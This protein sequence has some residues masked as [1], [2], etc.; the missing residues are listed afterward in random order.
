MA[1][2]HSP[3]QNIEAHIQG[4]ISGQVAVGNYNVQ[5]GSIHGGVVNLVSPEQ[6][7]CPRPRPSPVFLRPRPFPKLLDRESEV[8]A[9]TAALQSATPVEFYGQDGLGKTT[10]QRYL[11]YQPSLASFPDGVVY[12]SVRHQPLADLLQS[13][14]DAFY[15]SDVPFKPTDTQ[16]RHDLQGKRALI[17]LDDVGLTRDEV[18]TLMDAAP[19]CAFL[20]ASRQRH[21]WGEGRTMALRGLPPDNAMALLER[22]LGRPLTPE[23]RPAAQALCTALDGNPLRILQAAAMVREEGRSLTEVSRRIQAPSPADTLTAEILK[24]LPESKRQ[25]LAALAAL[26]GAPLHVDHLAALTGIANITPTLEALQSRNLVQAHSP[27]YSL[28]GTLGDDLRHQWD[29]NQWA[30]RA[31]AHFTAWAEENRSPPDRLL[32]ETDV[33]LQVLGWG[34]NAGRWAEVLRLARAAEGALALGRRWGA[35]GQTLQWA[36]QAARAQQ[37]RAAEAWVLHQLGTR[38]LCLSR[39]EE[40]R[41][42][43]SQ[44]L[45]IREAIDD[46]AGAAVTR[47]NLNLLPGVPPP[48]PRKPPGPKAGFSPA[49]RL[50]LLAGALLS[51]GLLAAI[52]IRVIALPTLLPTATPTPPRASTAMPAP[53]GIPTPTGKPT[54]T[55]RPTLTA[56]AMPA[57]TPAFTTSLPD[58]II[59]NVWNK[60]RRVIC[61]QIRNIGARTAPKGHSVLLLV[62]GKKQVKDFIRVEMPPEGQFDRCFDY[63]WHCTPPEDVIKVC[64][65]YKN[66]VTESIETNNCQEKIWKCAPI[67]TATPTSK[68]L[69]DFVAGANLAQWSSKAGTLPFPGQD[70]DEQGFVLWRHNALLENGSRFGQVLETHPQWVDYGYIEGIYKQTEEFT[71]EEGDR[72][73]ARV[74]FLKGAKAG[75]VTFSLYF[76]SSDVCFYGEE[77]PPL[78]GS[79]SDRYDGRIQKWEIPLGELAGQQGCFALR[80][81]AGKTS[82]QDWAV[83]AEAQIERP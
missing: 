41:T 67:P 75:D 48:P 60:K 15:E 11:S 13:L 12:L 19:G 65:D 37:D 52:A 7:P 53:T 62:D 46:R 83:W 31:M 5:I 74:G 71:I 78:V 66:D 54:L 9:A 27:R 26:N 3:D 58:L 49:I 35:W 17:L 70:T 61:Y 64:A 50:I 57:R 45:H 33:I 51:V 6:Q 36:L 30:E 69:F 38:T 23:E 81:N 34:V 4:K 42:F 47:H 16:I 82:T 77:F 22:E 14:F 68:V 44:A 55:A 43:L 24:G 10:L 73:V 59:T 2:F 25:V 1:H 79:L 39:T 18:E 56:T 63:G 76:S 29:L 40:A 28:T 80:V 21:L 32:A 72:F 8:G 20:L